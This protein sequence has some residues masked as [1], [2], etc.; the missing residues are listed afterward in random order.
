M[1]TLQMLL[2]ELPTCE[3]L[4]RAGD[5]EPLIRL[6]HMLVDMKMAEGPY[7]EVLPPNAQGAQAPITWEQR[8]RGF[9]IP[10]VPK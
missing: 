10:E 2:G 8:E 6:V 1:I 4:A 3:R 9:G 7:V 5:P